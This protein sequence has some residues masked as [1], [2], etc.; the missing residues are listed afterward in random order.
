[1][2]LILLIYYSLC[3]CIVLN[4]MW[5]GEEVVALSRVEFGEIEDFR[6]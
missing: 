6:T 2:K 5:S 1:M 3:V 4:I